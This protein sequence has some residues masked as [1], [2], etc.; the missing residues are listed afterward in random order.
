MVGDNLKHD[1]PTF[2]MAPGPVGGPAVPPTA[3][4]M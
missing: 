2:P 4:V 3:V 1:N